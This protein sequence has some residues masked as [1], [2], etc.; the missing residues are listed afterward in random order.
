MKFKK[1]DL[2]IPSIF[3]QILHGAQDEWSLNQFL[4][5]LLFQKKSVLKI[6]YK[7]K[8]FSLPFNHMYILT[9]LAFTLFNNSY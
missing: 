2:R 9:A 4:S 7:E 5:T 1:Q 6:Y 8:L 3:I